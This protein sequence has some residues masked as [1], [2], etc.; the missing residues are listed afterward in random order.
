MASSIQDNTADKTISQD[1]KTWVVVLVDDEPDNLSVASMLLTFQGATVHTAI[2]GVNALQVL[3]SVL[4]TFM[5]LDLSM[6]EMNG[7]ELFAK[8]RE[9]SKYSQVPIIA[10]TAHAMSGERQKVLEAGF[11]GYIAKPFRISTFLEKSKN[12][13]KI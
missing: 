12:V 8:L 5:L 2:D 9:D 4:P 7:W 3:E 11:D 10:L 1:M 6:P 13:C